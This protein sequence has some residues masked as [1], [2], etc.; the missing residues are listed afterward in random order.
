MCNGVLIY[1]CIDPEF[2]GLRVFLFR[3]GIDSSSLATKRQIKLISQS[4][5]YH[6]L[7]GWT[8]RQIFPKPTEKDFFSFSL[9]FIARPIRQVSDNQ[10]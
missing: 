2:Q 8:G 1:H 4:G 3:V 10:S 7:C 5:F 6:G 9:S